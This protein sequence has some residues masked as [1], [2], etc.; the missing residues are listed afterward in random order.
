ME[1]CDGG[2]WGRSRGALAGYAAAWFRNIRICLAC[3]FLC[4]KDILHLSDEAQSCKLRPPAHYLERWW[5][6]EDGEWEHSR[7]EGIALAMGIPLSRDPFIRTYIFLRGLGTQIRRGIHVLNNSIFGRIFCEQL[8]LQKHLIYLAG[9]H[10]SSCHI[11]SVHLSFYPLPLWG[12]L[13]EAS[14][15][16]AQAFWGN[17]TGTL[18]WEEE[19]RAKE[20]LY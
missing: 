3:V 9:S 18:L 2:D 8:Y 1:V 7:N 11:C 4:P 13:K 15:R 12:T 20:F 16:G 10:L 6:E 5:A 14:K 19:V 17:R